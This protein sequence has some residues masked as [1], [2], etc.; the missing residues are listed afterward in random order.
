MKLGAN[1]V[2]F[3]GYPLETAFRYL[4]M[5]GYDGVELSAIDGMSEHLVL[6]R[7]RELVPEIKRLSAT[8]GLE[9]LAIEQPSRDPVKMEKAMQAAV[10]L[11]IP[12]IN[13]GPGGKSGDEAS[14]QQSMEELAALAQMAERY[15]VTLCVK[16]HVGQAVYNTPTTLRMMEAISSPALGV[17]MDPSHIY[18][19][20]ENPVEA[21]AAVISRVKH[22]HIRDCKGRQQGPGKPEDQT[23]G[24]G[25][26][27]LVGYIR[28]LHEH[29]YTGPLDL[30][31]IGAK[32]YALE[33]CCI[34]AAEARGHMRACL[35]AC[36][37][38]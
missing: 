28:V 14:F 6:D 18:R 38:V 34:I 30:E 19:A 29:G 3:G 1:S 26:I 21:I 32:E 37:A 36:G 9:L 10:E 27:D 15:G 2:L 22:V 35:Q 12:I 33:Q 13:C 25:D 7:W 17:D 5:A 16:A 4:A 20:G 24:R 11:G 8:Y 31:I 23:N